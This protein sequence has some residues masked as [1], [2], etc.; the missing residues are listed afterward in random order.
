MASTSTTTSIPTPRRPRGRRAR[1]ISPTTRAGTRTAQ[2]AARS[3]EPT[4]GARTSTRSSS[5]CTATTH[6]VKPHV[7]FGVSPFGIPRPGRPEGVVGFDQYESLYAD[8][9]RWLRNGWC[10]YWSPQLYW[11]IDAPGQ[12]FR[13]LLE[14]LDLAERAGP[15]PLA[16]PQR[17]PDR[18]GRAIG[19]A[20]EEI[21][22][23]IA[24]IREIEGAD[25]NVLFSMKPLMENRRGFNDRLVEGLYR[26]A[27]LVPRVPLAGPRTA[28]EA[29]R[30][31][32]PCRR[33]GDPHDP[34]S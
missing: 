18:R 28:V 32:G 27:A 1:W 33:S 16:G 26:T 4:G 13:P 3:T 29:V 12:P 20:P 24:I 14:L 23:Q 21:L 11:K 9:E 15:P 30:H 8:T 19:Y 25:G 5:R 7:Q 2:R 22:G 34:S 31:V 10:D 6:E 17:Q